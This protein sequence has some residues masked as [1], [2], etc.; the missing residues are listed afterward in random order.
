MSVKPA[1]KTAKKTNNKKAKK[2]QPNKKKQLNKK[3][4][5][6][7]RLLL[8]VVAIMTIVLGILSGYLISRIY[9]TDEPEAEED[10]QIGEQSEDPDEENR[11]LEEGET[12]QEILN[13]AKQKSKEEAE[14]VR[15]EEVKMLEEEKAAL[16][17]EYNCDLIEESY[18]M[19]LSSAFTSYQTSMSGGIVCTNIMGECAAAKRIKDNYNNN[20]KEAYQEYSRQWQEQK[21]GDILPEPPYL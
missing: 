10:V 14:K 6:K 11:H 5:N 9:K 3:P 7:K 19:A 20:I 21:C 18:E 17:R 16:I 13:R 4:A 12:E 15:Q 8:V 1:K 2:T